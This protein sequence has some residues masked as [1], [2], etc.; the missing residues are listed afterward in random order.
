M[1]EIYGDKT[2]LIINIILNIV[3]YIAQYFIQ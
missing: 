1:F 2:F 3:I